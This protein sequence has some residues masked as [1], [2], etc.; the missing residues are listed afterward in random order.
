LANDVRLPVT[1]SFYILF[2]PFAKAIIG[3]SFIISD[4]FFLAFIFFCFI[5]A[6]FKKRFTL[7]SPDAFFLIF[8]SLT[9]SGKFIATHLQ[10]YLFEI[11]SFIYMYTGARCIASQIN[12]AEKLKRFTGIIVKMF[13]VFLLLSAILIVIKSL[14]FKQ[15]T[16]PF[17]IVQMKYKGFFELSNQLAVFLVCFWPLAVLNLAEKPGR[18]FSLYFIFFI[19]LSYTASRIGL[20]IGIGQTILVEAILCGKQQNNFLLT[21][22]FAL[23][24]IIFLVISIMATLPSM[25][26]S[27]GNIEKAGLT[28]DQPRI[29]TFRSAFNASMS[30]LTGYGLGCFDKSH[31]H[32]IHN[33]LFSLLVETGILGFLVLTLGI[34]VVFNAFLRSDSCYDMP[35]LK[36]A[37]IVSCLGIASIGTVHYLLRTRSCWLIFSIMLIIVKLQK[38]AVTNTNE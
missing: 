22:L 24:A 16:E 4:I 34:I 25:Q 31:P 3:Q 17:F 33:T 23:I 9:T 20:W 28:I 21:R 7:I 27:L 18:R 19:V 5:E 14:G 15:F 6:L 13:V 29:K 32:E 11:G 38:S 2:F 8:V 12:T 30:W 1:L 26:R 36:V 35:G 10:S 37:L